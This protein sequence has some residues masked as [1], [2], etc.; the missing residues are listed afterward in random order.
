MQ[1]P[2]GQRQPSKEGF[3]AELNPNAV[4]VTDAELEILYL[5][6]TSRSQ[7]PDLEELGQQHPVLQGLTVLSEQL[8]TQSE[9]LTTFV[10]EVKIDRKTF[11]E[12]IFALPQKRRIY[13]Y[14]ADVTERHWTEME[15]K[16]SETQLRSANLKLGE[17]L[18]LKDEFVANVSH[19]LRTPLTAIK[20]GVSLVLDEVSGAINEKQRRFL[21]IVKEEIN[22]LA[23]LITNMLDFSKIEAGKMPLVRR[24]VGPAELIEQTRQS[25]QRIA[26]K[27]RIVCDTRQAPAVFADPNRIL[28]VVGNLFSN[29]VKFTQEDGTITITAKERD[30]VVAVSVADDGVGIAKEDLPKLFQKFSQV[31]KQD[32]KPM[33]TGLGL[34]LCKE[35]VELHKETIR[36]TSTPGRGSTFTFTLPIYTSRLALEESFEELVAQ[37][38]RSDQESVGLIAIDGGPFSG[39]VPAPACEPGGPGGPAGE[40]EQPLW[41]VE[42]VATFVRTRVHRGDVVLTVEPQWVVI[43]A[44]TD[45]SDVQAMLGRLR[46]IVREWADQLVGA[47]VRIPVNIGT[48]N[49]PM[50]G[51]DVHSL[52]AKATSAIKDE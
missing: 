2:R 8:K 25:Y 43:L 32:D 48:A 10:R 17:L 36:V 47:Q 4:V 29:A 41:H 34:A 44:V 20:E 51:A 46:P 39:R 19:E 49:Y 13:L 11:E 37:A 42:Q 1:K 16:R 3:F 24:R 52:F 7:F 18:G 35:L 26:G 23:E 21:S 31:G 14:L 40:Q 9:G 15:L 5:N 28:Q 6:P 38:R 27:R 45:A 33:G 30:G 22:R 12:Q 50:D